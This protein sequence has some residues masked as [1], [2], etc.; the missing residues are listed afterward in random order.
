MKHINSYLKQTKGIIKPIISNTHTHTQEINNKKT[1]ISSLGYY[2]FLFS[3]F[4]FV[5]KFFAIIKC[6]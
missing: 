5:T 2:T 1:F 3:Y 6:S 4:F